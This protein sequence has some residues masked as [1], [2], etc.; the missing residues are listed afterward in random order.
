MSHSESTLGFEESATE[1]VRRL[2]RVVADFP[3]SGVHFADLTPVFA[4]GPAFAAV[5]EA[6]AE[7]GQGVDLVAGID[8]RGFLLGSGVALRLGVGVLPVRKAGKLPPP[9]HAQTYTLEYGTATLEVSAEAV[10]LA[11]RR[12]LVVDDV[13]ATGGTVAAAVELLHRCEAEVVGVAV[14]LEVAGL[15]GRELLAA[16]SA[17]GRVPLHCLVPA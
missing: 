3:V 14:A 16:S 12:I 13:L 8:A 2:T 5:I 6:L 11:G 9:V 10:P 1:Q 17:E 15:G 7:W 4:D